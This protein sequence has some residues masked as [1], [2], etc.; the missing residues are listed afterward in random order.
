MDLYNDS[1]EQN[2]TMEAGRRAQAEA[3]AR[4]VAEPVARRSFEIGA[5]RG[6]QKTEQDLGRLADMQSAFDRVQ[7]T[8][9]GIDVDPSDAALASDFI[10]MQQRAGMRPP[11]QAQVP[12]AQNRGGLGASIVSRAAQNNGMPQQQLRQNQAQS[13][14]SA[15]ERRQSPITA[16]AQKILRSINKDEVATG[17]NMV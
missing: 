13:P 9:P 7:R 6:Q 1:A 2:A 10:S 15:V 5:Q 4:K 12:V 17:Q 11:V 8:P 14:G 16:E 3:L